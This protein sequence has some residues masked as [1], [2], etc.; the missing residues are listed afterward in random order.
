MR[1]FQTDKQMNVVFNATCDF[2]N[3]AQT[4]NHAAEI[5]VEI[6]APRF[7]KERTPILRGE[8]DVVVKT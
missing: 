3:S 4:A 7:A 6:L 8:Y 1:G 5:F 2:R